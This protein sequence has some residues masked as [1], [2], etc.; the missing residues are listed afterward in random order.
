VRKKEMPKKLKEQKER[1]KGF[2]RKAGMPRRGQR[3]DKN[4]P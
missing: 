2:N 1:E 4:F 3:G